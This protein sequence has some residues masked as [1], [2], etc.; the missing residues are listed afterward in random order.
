MK[1]LHSLYLELTGQPWELP[2]YLNNHSLCKPCYICLELPLH[3]ADCL[4]C[5]HACF[6][7]RSLLRHSFNT[8]ASLST[9][10]HRDLDS[11]YLDATPDYMHIPSA[12]CRIA[13]VFPKAKLVVMIKDPVM[14]ALSG[15]NMV[16]HQ[17]K[18]DVRSFGEEVS[19]TGRVRQGFG[20]ELGGRCTLLLWPRVAYVAQQRCRL[21]PRLD[22]RLGKARGGPGLMLSF[23]TA[24]QPVGCCPREMPACIS[25]LTLPCR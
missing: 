21:V 9:L 19:G 20:G 1:K 25:L 4:R 12:A 10:P 3:T 6:T 23:L 7:S 18:F 17:G 22:M 2:S 15:W 14:R 8:P 16:R 5:C 11:T 24:R 13:S